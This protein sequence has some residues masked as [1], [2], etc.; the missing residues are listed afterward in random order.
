MLW[1]TTLVVENKVC[2]QCKVIRRHAASHVSFIRQ[3]CEKYK[4]NLD[5]SWMRKRSRSGFTP[6]TE[7]L[8]GAIQQNEICTF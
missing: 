8:H 3:F 2:T 1:L 5:Y 7:E 6:S 4:N